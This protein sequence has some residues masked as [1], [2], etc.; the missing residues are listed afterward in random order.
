MTQRKLN[1]ELARM[2]R[3]DGLSNREI[4]AALEVHE[5]TV[6]RALGPKPKRVRRRVTF[7]VVEECV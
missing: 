2:A 4:A 1:V 5:S 6:R 3:E 7:I